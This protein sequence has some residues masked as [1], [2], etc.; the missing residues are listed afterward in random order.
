MPTWSDKL[1]QEVIRS[2][3]EAYYE[4]QFSEHA[5][6]FRPGRGCHTALHTIQ[7][8]WTGTRWFI[9]GDIAGCFD[10]IDHSILLSILGERI[11]DHRFL[12]LIQ[13]MLQAGY[14]NQWNWTP[15]HS[16]TPQG[17]VVSPLLANI[18]LDKLDQFVVAE[19]IPASTRGARRQL[20]PAYNRLK[21]RWNYWRKRGQRA[22]ARRL[23]QRMQATPSGDPYDAGFRRLRYVR[24]ADDFLLGFIGS[25]AEAEVLK[26]RLAAFLRTT[27]RLELSEAKT[28][29]TNATRQSARFL[30]YEI[31]NQQNDARRD[32]HGQRNVNGRIGL[33]VPQAVIAARSQR[34]MRQG[35]ASHR[36]ELIFESD[37]SIITRYQQEYRGI[38]QYYALAVNRS[39]LWRL[40]YVV[41]TSLLRTLAA[42]HR[43]TVSAMFRRYRATVPTPD[44]QG[45][46]RCLEVR[47]ERSEGRPPLIARFG[48]ISLRRDENAVL[49]DG[50]T[51]LRRTAGRSELLTRLLADRCELCGATEN[52][53]V[54]HIRKLADLKVKGRKERPHWVQRMAALR[55]KT[56]VVCQTCHI[57]I[58]NGQPTRQPRDALLESRV[59]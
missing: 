4:P 37:Y 7:T 2:L 24:Y 29:I 35:K 19:L 26:Q 34:Y 15:T 30:G 31:R 39:K 45:T 51:D 41:Q 22:Q 33:R 5:H 47:V 8:T 28:L 54:H 48:G 27:L 44:G 58:H 38:V 3:L 52:I 53:E 21:T 50:P 1:L 13:H 46:L 49:Y 18:Y 11:H 59:R 9:E 55:R 40:H 6:G 16:G 25:R 20:N 10:N 14:G 36:N 32:R 12:R 17:G 42:K 23:R 43:S 56:L 57:A